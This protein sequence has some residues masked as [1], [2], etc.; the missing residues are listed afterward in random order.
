MRRFAYLCLIAL[1]VGAAAWAWYDVPGFADKVSG[2]AANVPGLAANVP[3]FAAKNQPAAKAAA[4][5]PVHTALVQ[6]KSFPVILNGLG[7][8]QA[9]NTVTVRSRVDG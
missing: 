9:T 7:T 8:V 2:F 3:G 1:G 4:A 5:A 6:S